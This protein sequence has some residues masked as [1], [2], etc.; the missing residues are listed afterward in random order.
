VVIRSRITSAD[1]SGKCDP[2]DVVA[3]AEEAFSR[4][5]SLASRWYLATALLF[6]ASDR[7]VR[8]D[9]K[10][11]ALRHRSFRSV[12]VNE[13]FGAVLSVD[14]PLKKKAIDDADVHRA[15]DLV[16]ESLVAAPSYTIGPLWWSLLQA[17]NPADGTAM[18]A[19]YGKNEWE[20][21]QDEIIARLDPYDPSNTLRAYWRARM[22]NHEDEA[23]KI[24]K[25][26]DPNAFPVPIDSP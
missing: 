5:P 23:L 7:L 24:L 12:S 22:G 11:A 1:Y 13:L 18:A 6:R 2:N 15:L 3:L 9:S 26:A 21:L 19:L 4:S 20:P 17:R 8:A 16:H 14:G 10:F 25:N